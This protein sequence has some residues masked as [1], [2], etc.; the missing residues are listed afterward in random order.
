MSY[1][2]KEI[3]FVINK[4]F[5]ITIFYKLLSAHQSS[6]RCI[7]LW[8][9]RSHLEHSSFAAT[10]LYASN[11][12]KTVPFASYSSAIMGF[13]HHSISSSNLISSHLKLK[14]LE[15]RRK[16]NDLYFLHTLLNVSIL[17]ECPLSRISINVCYRV[18]F[19]L[20]LA[21]CFHL[22]L[23]IPFLTKWLIISTPFIHG[24]I[25]LASFFCFQ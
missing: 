2:P 24:L 10:V 1:S 5:Y 25:F 16:K 6:K 14:S 11:G 7:W 8:V 12:Y 22:I 3:K 15:L 4:F 13:F 20:N 21:D 9:I 17:N 23:P 19:V 18:R